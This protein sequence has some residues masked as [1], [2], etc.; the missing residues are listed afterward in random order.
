MKYPIFDL[1]PSIAQFFYKLFRNFADNQDRRTI[2]DKFELFIPKI[3]GYDK[4]SARVQL[5][6]RCPIGDLFVKYELTRGTQSYNPVCDP[7]TLVPPYKL[8]LIYLSFSGLS[9]ENFKR[10]PISV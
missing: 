4:I 10:D 6:N 2:L 1:I 8:S 3:N 9:N 7:F 5:S